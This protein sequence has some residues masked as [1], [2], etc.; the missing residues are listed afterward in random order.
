MTVTVS[1]LSAQCFLHISCCLLPAACCQPPLPRP[2]RISRCP[3]PGHVACAAS[4]SCY[5][6]GPRWSR[7]GLLRLLRERGMRVRFA[8][9]TPASPGRHDTTCAAKWYLCTVRSNLGEY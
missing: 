3:P 4:L 6:A 7:S 8:G 9:A 1:W 5:T 2:F